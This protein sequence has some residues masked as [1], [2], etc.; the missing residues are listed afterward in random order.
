M[1]FQGKLW[2]K[3]IQPRDWQKK[4]FEK[5]RELEKGIVKIATGGGKTIFAFACINQ[6]QEKYQDAKIV[7]VVPTISL[8]DQ[9]ILSLTEDLQIDEAEI[10]SKCSTKLANKNFHV[11]V[12]NSAR[13]LKIIEQ[14]C[15]LIVDEC[16]R[17]ASEIN[18]DVFKNEFKATLGLSATPERQFDDLFEKILIPSLGPIIFN[19]SLA[20]GLNDKILSPFQIKNIKI[21]L[22]EIEFKY[23]KKQSSKIAQV[24]EQEGESSEFLKLLLLQRARGLARAS[25]RIPFAIKIALQHEDSK[26]IIFHES[27]ASANAIANGLNKAGKRSVIYHS[28]IGENLRRDNLRLFKKGIANVLIC[29]RALD[30]GINIPDASIGIIASSTTSSRQR[31]QRLGRIL[32]PSPGKDMAIIFTLYATPAEKSRLKKEEIELIDSVQVE[33]IQGSVQI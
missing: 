12:L 19:Y 32:R 5:W 3:Q 17:S 30:E 21:P 10:A 31:I 25:F 9:W 7:I 16:H 24:F 13:K 33:W 27:I 18:S 1:S 20:D 26:I 15:F 23:Y 28:K 22:T 14:N 8:Q 11:L 4:A 2:N 6:F 29:C